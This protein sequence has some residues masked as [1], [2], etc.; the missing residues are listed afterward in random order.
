[1]SFFAEA[2]RPASIDA[3]DVSTITAHHQQQQQQASLA[4]S[5]MLTPSS[6]STGLSARPYI[7]ATH[8]YV[9]YLAFSPFARPKATSYSNV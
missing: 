5:T 7:S 8:I 4:D 3:E 9:C 6:Q 2:D 1:M